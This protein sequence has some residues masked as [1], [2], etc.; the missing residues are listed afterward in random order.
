LGRWQC[1]RCSYIVEGENAPE[2]C[3][4]C[5]YSI[6][7]WVEQAEEKPQTL[8][9]YVRTNLVRMDGNESAWNAARVMKERDTENVLVTTGG[10][11]T[12]MVTERDIV[13]K[14]AAEDLNAS[15]VPL[16]NIMSTALVSAPSDTS[17]AEG[18]RIMAAHHIRRLIV[19]ENGNPIGVVSHRSILGGSF[20]ATGD[21][22]PGQE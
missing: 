21:T 6:S 1:Y 11:L 14:V 3:P 16:S 2:E 4:N 9:D 7:F 20:R 10:K 18:L 22:P 8:K 12:G 17:V 5:H 15:K 13:N 19:T